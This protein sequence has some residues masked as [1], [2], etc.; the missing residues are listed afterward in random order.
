MLIQAPLLD[1]DWHK[2]CVIVEIII[3]ELGSFY[4]DFFTGY[5]DDA[6]LEARR[7]LLP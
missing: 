6:A 1:D 7:D 2:S 3:E 4:F 5:F